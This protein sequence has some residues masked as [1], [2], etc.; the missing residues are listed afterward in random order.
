MDSAVALDPDEP[1]VRLIRAVNST[2]VPKM[3]NRLK[4]AVADFKD[5]R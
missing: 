4:M 5:V 3:F 2:S 1:E